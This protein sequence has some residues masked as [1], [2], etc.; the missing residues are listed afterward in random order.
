MNIIAADASGRR[1]RVKG[2]PPGHPDIA[3]VL[4]GGRALFVEV[5]AWGGRLTPQQITFQAD[6]ITQGAL[7]LTIRSVEELRQG[8]RAAG[9]EAP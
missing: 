9:I 4:P 7:V 1:R 8:L 5:K 6:M 2:L 3:G